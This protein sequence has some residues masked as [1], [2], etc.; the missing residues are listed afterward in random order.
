MDCPNDLNKDVSRYEYKNLSNNCFP[1]GQN[2]RNKTRVKEGYLDTHLYMQDHLQV[3]EDKTEK[4]GG[5]LFGW[6]MLAHVRS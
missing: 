5:Y 2:G 3:P 4:F 6:R 1:S